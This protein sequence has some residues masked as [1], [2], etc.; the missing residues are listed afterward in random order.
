MLILI[1]VLC[2][3]GQW[4]HQGSVIL[5]SAL[6]LSFLLS[7]RLSRLFSCPPSLQPFLQCAVS[8]QLGVF[9]FRGEKFKQHSSFSAPTVKSLQRESPVQLQ[10]SYTASHWTS[11]TE[12]NSQAINL[13][14]Q[15]S[16]IGSLIDRL[17]IFSS[18]DLCSSFVSL[19]N[20][21]RTTNLLQMKTSLSVLLVH[22]RSLLQTECIY[23]VFLVWL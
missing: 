12:T 11:S 20:L 9:I 3:L 18:A 4:P 22:Q 16:M 13:A 21:S 10:F 5:A 14:T 2:F 17:M 8:G 1:R 19:S 7:F 6:Q 15:V 23:V